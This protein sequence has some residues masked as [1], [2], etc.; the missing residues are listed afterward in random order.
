MVF[1][2]PLYV[3]K[4][5]SRDYFK[6][7]LRLTMKKTLEKP[8]ST[9]RGEKNTIS[10]PE[11]KIVTRKIFLST[12]ILLTIMKIVI[13]GLYLL[14]CLFFEI[15]ELDQYT[16]THMCLWIYTYTLHKAKIW[17]LFFWAQIE[18]TKPPDPPDYKNN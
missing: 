18:N 5:F 15:F 6:V 3:E 7:R 17:K 10:T 8:F 11:K 1:F 2:S 16:C 14:G 12:W 13:S 9:S 4:G